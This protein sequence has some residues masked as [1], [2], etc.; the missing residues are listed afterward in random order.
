MREEAK[1]VTELLCDSFWLG[2]WEVHLWDRLENIL[3]V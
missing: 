2:T 3:A 1:C